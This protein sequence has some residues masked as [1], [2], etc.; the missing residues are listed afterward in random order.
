MGGVVEL[1]AGRQPIDDQYSTQ[2]T[3]PIIVGRGIPCM[4][5]EIQGFHFGMIVIQAIANKVAFRLWAM[6]VCHGN[7]DV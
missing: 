2:F 5:F 7:S 3:V 4:R 6:F 1:V